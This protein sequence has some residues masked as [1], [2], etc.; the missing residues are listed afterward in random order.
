MSVIPFLII[1]A[2]PAGLAA[3]IAYGK[4]AVILE[5]NSE[6]GKKLLLSGSGQCNFTN[7]LP[8]EDFLRACRKAGPFLKP[9]IYGYGSDFFIDLLSKAGCA[10]LVREDGKVFPAS[11]KAAQ[12][13]DALL[14]TALGRGAEI[15]YETR[16]LE[17]VKQKRSFLVRTETQA[18]Q[19]EK[20]LLACGGSSWSQTGSQGDGY[21]FAAALGHKINSVRPALASVE[22]EETNSFSYCAG[23]TVEQVEAVFLTASGK[24]KDTGDLLFTH[25]GL[26][27]PLILNNSYLLSAGDVIRIHLLP[28]AE[29]LVSKAL[30][31]NT[32]RLVLNALRGLPLTEAIMASVLHYLGIYTDTLV[33]SLSKKQI[34]K[35]TGFLQAAEFYVKKVESLE[36]SM[37]TAG[38]VLLSEV[39]AGSMQS[40]VVN[41]LFL[42]GEVLDY[43][44][45]SGGFNIQAAFSTGWLAGVSAL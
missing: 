1:G 22:T 20:L 10:S 38:G 33:T 16:V 32:Q 35:L 14:K 41:G 8:R 4:G 27:G 45:P 43:A 40:R 19:A 15:I 36:T 5:G 12:V 11:L 34:H 44:L 39:E 7:N 9:A 26:S 2:G 37:S 3:A 17:V 25:R 6:A 28:Q 31:Q 24:H 13:R 21:V 29:A 18:Y 42:A 30:E 23:S